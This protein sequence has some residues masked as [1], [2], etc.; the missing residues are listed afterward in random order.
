MPT[1]AS[2]VPHVHGPL[3]GRDRAM[4]LASEVFRID[5]RDPAESRRHFDAIGAIAA[6]VPLEVA[7]RRAPETAASELLCRM[8][9]GW[10]L[11]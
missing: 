2:I 6:T 5:W 7:E 10:R 3:R 1:A 11:L 8:T 9:E 4:A